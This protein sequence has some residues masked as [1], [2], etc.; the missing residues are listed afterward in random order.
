MIDNQ[1]FFFFSWFKAML[2]P[3]KQNL[4]LLKSQIKLVKNGLKLLKEK[5]SGLIY[6]FLELSKKGKEMEL[7][8]SDQVTDILE[9]Y[10]IDTALVST[11]SLIEALEATPAMDLVTKKKRISGVYVDDLDIKLTSPKRDNLK[12]GIRDVLSLFA[13]FFPIILELSQLKLNVQRIATEIQKVGRQI[14]NLERKVE[15]INAQIK[16]IK[17]A[18]MEKEN[19]EKAVSIKLFT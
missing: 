15:D 5:R 10:E 8:I 6:T 16:F 7:K 4:L 3:N 17:T 14:S 11:Y 9:K 18:L 13:S 19:F 12:T 2:A 1:V